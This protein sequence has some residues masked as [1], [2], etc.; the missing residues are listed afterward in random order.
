PRIRG[1]TRSWTVEA[2]GP[3]HML[4]VKMTGNAS[5]NA[6]VGEAVVSIQTPKGRLSNGPAAPTWSLPAGVRARRES[7]QT[8]PSVVP[9]QPA[10]AEMTPRT[11]PVRP[12]SGPE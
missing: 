2:P 7:A 5:V 11:S 3:I 9:S 10:A 4:D 1:N 6:V 8:P 12:G